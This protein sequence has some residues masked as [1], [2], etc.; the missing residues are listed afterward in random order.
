MLFITTESHFTP[1]VGLESI[2][3]PYAMNSQSPLFYALNLSSALY[4]LE[5]YFF[6]LENSS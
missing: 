2:K 1:G 3:N 4:I 6:S 5:K